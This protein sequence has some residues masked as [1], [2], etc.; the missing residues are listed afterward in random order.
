MKSLLHVPAAALLMCGLVP[1]ATA[2]TTG[3]LEIDFTSVVL[4]L[5][6][7]LTALIAIVVGVSGICA[8]RRRGRRARHA[9][10]TVL[11]IGAVLAAVMLDV[12]P[13]SNAQATGGIP[14]FLGVSPAFAPVSFNGS[15]FQVINGT[16]GT[17]TLTAVQLVGANGQVN[18][19]ATTC[20]VGLSLP[21]GAS[22]FVSVPSVF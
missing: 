7:G 3:Q 22:C 13:L 11:G 10:W 17:V 18:P 9:T 14:L 6:S 12:R 5:S 8:Q 19:G 1:V 2:Q 21:S 16:S 20:V 4:P 15:D